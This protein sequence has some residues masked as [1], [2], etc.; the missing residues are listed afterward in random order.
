MELDPLAAFLPFPETGGH[1]LDEDESHAGGTFVAPP[2]VSG[3]LF[4]HTF[5]NELVS[6]AKTHHV[7]VVFRQETSRVVGPREPRVAGED[8]RSVA[9]D[10]DLFELQ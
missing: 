2:P 7:D 9:F 3:D 5:G 1:A 6:F 10:I 4:A 8:K